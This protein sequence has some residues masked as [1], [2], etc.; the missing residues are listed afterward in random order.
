MSSASRAT[1]AVCEAAQ[2]RP[3]PGPGADRSIT[4]AGRIVR[5]PLGKAQCSRCG[6]VQ[7]T[8]APF[9]ARTDFYEK[10]YSF[11]DRPGADRFDRER[12]LAMA[13]WIAAALP[14]P[15]ARVLDAGCGRGWMLEAMVSVYPQSRF[16]GIEPSE[17][18]SHNAR[19]R[20]FDVVTGRVDRGTAREGAYDLIYSTNVLEHTESPAQ[21]LADL[22]GMLAPGGQIVITCPDASRPNSEMLFSDQNFSF[23]PSHLETLAAKADLEVA[24]WTGP[25]GSVTSLR[26]KQLVV[27][28]ASRSAATGVVRFDSPDVERL[29]RERCEYLH[30]WT[31]CGEMLDREC[32]AA[33]RV[34]NFGTSTWSFL[35]AGYCPAYWARVT[36][37]TIDGGAGE[38]LGKPVTDAAVL[39]PAAGDVVVLGVDPASQSRLA[40]RFAGCAGRVVAWNDIVDR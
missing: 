20:G 7:R 38:F 26:D 6:L 18:E 39:S 32:G 10:H 30:A 40:A 22:R 27:L 35:L 34:C 29:F 28:R 23:L 16:S 37:C 17:S 36:S 1:C 14:A 31:R 19:Q 12:Y 2:W 9:L 13:N 4:T 25:P 8:A 21:F 15:P 33:R 11:Y 5:E 3:L 24:A